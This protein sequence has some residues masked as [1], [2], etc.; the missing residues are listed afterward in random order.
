MVASRFRKSPARGSPRGNKQG[1]AFQDII[2]FFEATT[3]AFGA[4]AIDRILKSYAAG[5]AG[6]RLVKQTSSKY[7][8]DTLLKK[9]I[10]SCPAV[11]WEN[12]LWS[13]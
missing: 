11:T 1:A 6:F 13:T 12:S 3:R 8:S 4:S 7:S 9:E 10:R 2:T 5:A